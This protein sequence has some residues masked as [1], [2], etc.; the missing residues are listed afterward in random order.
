MNQYYTQLTEDTRSLPNGWLGLCGWFAPPDKRLPDGLRAM[1]HLQAG[2]I[3]NNRRRGALST[4]IALRQAF[5]TIGHSLRSV[6]DSN[7]FTLA[8]GTGTTNRG[9]AIAER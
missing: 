5:L 4:D 7:S 2:I 1:M 8:N 3:K 9:E 6:M